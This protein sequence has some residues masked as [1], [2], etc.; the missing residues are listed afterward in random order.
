MARAAV[1]AKQQARAKAQPPAKQTRGKRRGAGGGNPNQNLFFMRLRRRQKWVFLALAVIF[2]ATFAG[3]GVGSGNSAGLDQ[4]FSGILGGGGGTSVSK[5]QDEVKTN[6]AKGYKD[7]VQAYLAQNDNG[8]AIGA[9]QSYLKLKKGAKDASAWTQLGSLEQ[10][11][12]QSF[13]TAYQQAQQQSQLADPAQAIQPTG[14]VSQQLPANPVDQ[15]YAQQASS[16]SSQFAQLATSSYSLA[17]QAYQQVAKLQPHNAGA[18]LQVAQIAGISNQTAVALKAYQR[19][20]QLSPHS[21]YLA[22]VEQTCHRLGG[23]CTPQYV[24]TLPKSKK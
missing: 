8:D 22:Q 18:Q 15:Y 4:L 7:L 9:L 23:I 17:L 14:P 1:K 12:A 13:V 24:K 21:P 10:Q 20:V 3:V 16:Q 5:A 6:P 19:Y 2:A 11:Q